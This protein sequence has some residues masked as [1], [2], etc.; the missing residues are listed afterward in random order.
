MNLA[1]I[2]AGYVGLVAGTC[3]AETGN[4]V[5]CVDIDPAKVAKLQKGEPTIF[6]PGL[7]ELMLKNQEEGRLFFTTDLLDAVRKSSVVFLA[8]GTPSSIDGSADLTAVLNVAA[9]IAK[10]MNG[11]KVI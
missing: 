7:K 5:I 6:E 9:G 3:F 1:V 11:P 10:A 2:G 8:V 4:D